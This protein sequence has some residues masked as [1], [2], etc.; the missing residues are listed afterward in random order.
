MGTTYTTVEIV[1]KRLKE[2]PSGLTSDD[3]TENII[4]A[5]GVVDS[6]MLMTGRG[7]ETDFVFDA[8]KH[9]I[10]RQVTTD[11][12]A[13]LCVCYDVSSQETLDSTELFANMMWN[14][15]EFSMGKLKDVRTVNLIKKNS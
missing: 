9:G 6:V 7:T 3:I 1:R 14:T 2:M 5:E 4:Q 11:L 8:A 15:I 10:I 13:F 12:A